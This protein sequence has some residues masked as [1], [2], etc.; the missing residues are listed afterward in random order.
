MAINSITTNYTG[1]KL[2][3]HIMQGVKAPLASNISLGFGRIS[4][5]C[6]GVQKLIQRYTIMLL[7]EIGSQENFPTFGSNLIVKLTS[8]SNNYNRSDLFALFALANLKVSNDI[9]EYQINNP[10]PEDEQL[11]TA[12]LEDIVTTTDGGVAMRVLITPRTQEAVDFI[13]PL[14]N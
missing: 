6:S 13:I 11:S 7:T 9:F 10:L 4:N 1:R 8:T 5:Y 12:S 2:D 3:L 14:P